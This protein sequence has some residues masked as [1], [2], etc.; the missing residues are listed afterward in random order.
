MPAYTVPVPRYWRRIGTYYR[1]EASRCRNCGRVY[2]PPR[3]RCVCGCKDMEKIRLL[4]GKFQLIDF[5]VLHSVSEDFEKQKPIFVGI[6]EESSTNVRIITQIVDVADVSDLE[7]SREVEPV[8]RVVKR[9][10]NVGII[11]YGTKF[12]PKIVG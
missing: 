8:F 3:M 7:K 6:V 1:L 9:D 10:G 5:T 12:R 2:Y 11:C 4:G